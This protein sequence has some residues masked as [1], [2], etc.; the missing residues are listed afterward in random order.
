MNSNVINGLPL[1]EALLAAIREERWT[2]PDPAVLAKVFGEQPD[3][4]SFYTLQQME[5][6]NR[7]WLGRTGPVFLGTPDAVR[8]PGNLDPRNSLIIGDLGPDMPFALDYR[9]AI[10]PTV[11]YREADGKWALVAPSIERLLE[12]LRG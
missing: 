11:V 12:R 9:P 5:F 7:H 4:P 6:E 1:P 8:P 3:G 10:G 2:P